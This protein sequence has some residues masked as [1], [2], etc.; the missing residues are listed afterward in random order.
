[1]EHLNTLDAVFLGLEDEDV[2]ANIGGVSIFEGPVPSHAELCARIESKLPLVPR[3]RQRLK[4]LPGNVGHPLWIDDTEFDIANHMIS[5]SLPGGTLA[6]V[7][8]MYTEMMSSHLERDLPLWQLWSVDGLEH[9]QWAILWKVHHALVDGVAATDV[10]NLLLDA[11]AE[12]AP[13]E[14]EP[15]VPRDEPGAA[16]VMLESVTGALRPAQN[17]LDDVEKAVRRPRKAA[18]R[19]WTTVRTMLPVG[20]SLATPQDHP[21]NGPIG[22]QRRW[23]GTEVDLAEIKTIGRAFGGTVNDVVLVA[24]T[25]GLAELL[26]QRGESLTDLTTR[27]MVPVSMRSED[28]RGQCNN[29]VSAVFVDLP[30]G[31]DDPA[32]QMADIQRQMEH[33]KQTDGAKAGEMLTTLADYAPPMLFALG[34]R[35]VWRIG[36]TQRLMNTI[37]TNV[38]GPQFPLYCLGRRMVKI[39]P[40]VML[41]KNIRLATAIF[42]YDG[43]VYF[44][45]TGDYESVPDLD[46]MCAG[47][48]HGV[49]KLLAAASGEQHGSLAAGR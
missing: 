36:D 44:G 31:L 21:L 37:A 48:E 16:R 5:R 11:E 6:D 14:A 45:V 38:P 9:G 8:R 32:E 22:P 30:V 13:V 24:V 3:Y 41:A 42:S 15:W 25:A 29:I 2:Q 18:R 49:A 46:N 10:M 27:T 35:F 1:M 19:A 23:C 34:E 39:F 4:F 28:E 7:R 12:P 17:V 33:Y 47:I 40:Y 26:R 20:R 43:G